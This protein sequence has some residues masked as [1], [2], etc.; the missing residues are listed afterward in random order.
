MGYAPAYDTA[1]P[2]THPEWSLCG[3]DVKIGKYGSAALNTKSA[4]NNAQD[5]VGL[6]AI[7]S[8][9]CHQDAVNNPMVTK[10]LYDGDDMPEEDWQNL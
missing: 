8:V 3:L 2:T 4:N 7:K 9:W 5:T 1:Y 10:T 6:G